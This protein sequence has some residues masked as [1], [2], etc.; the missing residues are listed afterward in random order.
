MGAVRLGLTRSFEFRALESLS[1]EVKFLEPAVCT[2]Q[3]HSDLTIPSWSMYS[4]LTY[5]GLQ[6]VPI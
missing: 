6:V 1:L 4:Y 2:A 5:I 3:R